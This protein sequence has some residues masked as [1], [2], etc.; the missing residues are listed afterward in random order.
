MAIKAGF[1]NS[2]AGQFVRLMLDDAKYD[3]AL[4]TA[5]GISFTPPT[6]GTRYPFRSQRAALKTGAI[7]RAT[8]TVKLGKRTRRITVVADKDQA[9]TLANA[10]VGQKIKIGGNTKVDWDV[11]DVVMG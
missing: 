11:T 1:I 10:L 2:G 7:V 9:D 6:S 8:V 4:A 5:C 3:S